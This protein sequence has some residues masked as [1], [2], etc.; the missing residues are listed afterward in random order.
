MQTENLEN[1]NKISS[2]RFENFFKVYEDKQN[3]NLFYNILKNIKIEKTNDD[4]YEDEYITKPNDTYPNIS[5]KYYN[6]I[7]LWWLICEYN[8]VK[9]PVK[10]IE[11]G[12]KLKILKSE[13][14][15][16]VIRELLNQLNR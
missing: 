4:Q 15:Y 14:V 10:K 6:T 2:Y 7:D 9:N 8:G 12:T 1:P 3:K 5:Y 16:I 11:T 13:Y